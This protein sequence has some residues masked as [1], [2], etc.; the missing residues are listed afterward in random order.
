MLPYESEAVREARRLA[1]A[2][3]RWEFHQK[4][5][6]YDEAERRLREDDERIFFDE[7]RAKRLRERGGT[8]AEQKRRERYANHWWNDEREAEWKRQYWEK[9]YLERRTREEPTSS[10]AAVP[11]VPAIDAGEA[12]ALLLGAAAAE[13][14]QYTKKELRKIGAAGRRSTP[15]HTWYKPLTMAERARAKLDMYSA[16][17][18]QILPLGRVVLRGTQK[19]RPVLRVQQSTDG[20]TYE[21]NPEGPW[22]IAEPLFLDRRFSR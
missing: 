1:Y 17:T 12:R 14:E 11:A 22:P 9:K 20:G 2:T 19:G 15:T 3:R 7:A 16:A 10:R 18:A 8:Y 5:H 6:Y 4:Y 13:V 21:V